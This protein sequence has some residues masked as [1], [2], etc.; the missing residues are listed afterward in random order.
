[1]GVT[2]VPA[3]YQVKNRLEFSQLDDSYS[4]WNRAVPGSGLSDTKTFDAPNHKAITRIE[5]ITTRGNPGWNRRPGHYDQPEQATHKWPN[6]DRGGNCVHTRY[7]FMRDPQLSYTYAG[8]GLFNI[9]T[10]IW[11]SP[12]GLNGDPEWAIRGAFPAAPSDDALDTLGTNVSSYMSPTR[13]RAALFTTIV[14]CYREGLP[15]LSS[16]LKRGRV[17][18]GGS[19]DWL[20]FSFG[21]KPL[22]NDLMSVAQAMLDVDSLLEQWQRDSG[23][24]VRRRTQR[25]PVVIDRSHQ[26]FPDS[27]GYPPLINSSY[28]RSGIRSVDSY[29]E[30]ETWFS[31]AFKYKVH[32]DPSFLGQVK[33]LNE[34][35]RYILGLSFDP[36][37]IWSVL[38]W[39]WLVDW[40]FNVGPV[41]E[42]FTQNYMN[43]SV[44]AYGYMMSKETFQYSESLSNLEIYLPTGGFTTV[45]AYSGVN[46]STFKRRQATPFGFGLNWTGFS[47][48]QLSILAALG[49]SRR[50]P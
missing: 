9:Q 35:A 46:Y 30:T 10:P 23:K 24:L 40:V 36:K 22:W 3:E 16:A 4:S 21:I 18:G 15:A 19:E 11:T 37:T 7:D 17:L 41:L 5:S 32:F 1:M 42:N 2:L 43:E 49:L 12:W 33:Y 20:N 8:N 38:G 45:Q 29:R 47:P 25:K 27:V 28:K 50:R 34:G 31:G 39:S 6:T 14:E 44:M 13:P 26:A 48:F